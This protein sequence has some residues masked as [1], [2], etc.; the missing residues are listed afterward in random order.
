VSADEL[1]AQ[2]LEV[3]ISSFQFCGLS[4]SGQ[5]GLRKY[6]GG[7]P[8]WCAIARLLSLVHTSHPAFGMSAVLDALLSVCCLPIVH[9]TL[10]VPLPSHIFLKQVH[11]ASRLSCVDFSH[12]ARFSPLLHR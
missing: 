2:A 1:V 3:S 6:I 7:G 9:V 11:T 4:P 12:E 8:Y 10:L 5:S